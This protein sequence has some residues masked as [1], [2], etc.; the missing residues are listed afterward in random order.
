MSNKNSG[1]SIIA[2]RYATALI[3]LGEKFDQ[4]DIFD[5]DLSNINASFEQN[6]ELLTFLKHPSI[7]LD[8]KKD[9]IDTIYRNYVSQHTLNLLKLLLDR[10]RIF[11]FPSITSHYTDILNTKRNIVIAKVITAIEIDEEIRNKV[12]SKLENVL[13]KNVKME[14]KIDPEIIAGMIVKISDR[15]IDGSTK[16]KLEKM[17]KQLK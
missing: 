7:P 12:K 15:I 17:K 4:L 13:N 10:N 6:K 11:I 16:T 14:I 5:A 9:F 1:L 8:E 3:E 2:N